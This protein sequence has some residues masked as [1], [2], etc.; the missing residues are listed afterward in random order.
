MPDPTID[1]GPQSPQKHRY[2]AIVIAEGDTISEVVRALNVVQAHLN[3]GI[4]SR[5]DQGKSGAIRYLLTER[6]DLAGPD[7]HACT[8]CRQPILAD[9]EPK[10]WDPEHG[11]A[12]ERCLDREKRGTREKRT[13][14]RAVPLNEPDQVA[15]FALRTP[16]VGE[17]ADGCRRSAQ[18]DRE[19]ADTLPLPGQPGHGP[20]A[21]AR[22][23]HLL[24]SA[25]AWDL[26]AARLEREGGEG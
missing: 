6:Q 24:A 14:L 13:H 26:Q 7:P 10:A 16:Y 11:H 8:V 25:A 18:V 22:R 19:E 5:A 21:D 2:A 1:L 20:N 3:V 12:H 15:G 23:D 4:T 17:G 9:N